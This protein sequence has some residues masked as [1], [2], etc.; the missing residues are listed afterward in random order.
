MTNMRARV[1]LFLAGLFLPLALSSCGNA[2]AL[3]PAI[4]SAQ[5]NSPGGYIKHVVIIVQENRSFDNLFAKFPGA[6][7]AASGAMSNGRVI[8]LKESTLYDPNFLGHKH[9]DFATD[10]AGGKMD[11]GIGLRANGFN[12]RCAYQYVDPKQIE[13]YWTMAHSMR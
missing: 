6:D 7:G 13:P 9:A 8:K 5:T 10:Y 12:P 11:G 4:P 2:P 1:K 3:Q